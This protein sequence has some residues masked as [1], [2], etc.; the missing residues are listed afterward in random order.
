[1]K[2]SE[3]QAFLQ[4]WCSAKTAKNMKQ[5]LYNLDLYVETGSLDPKF[6]L[7]LA[8]SMKVSRS[9]AN[10][11]EMTR[12]FATVPDH[13]FDD[14][15]KKDPFGINTLKHFL[16]EIKPSQTEYA[17]IT[18]F[19]DSS[20]GSLGEIDA[21]TGHIFT[22]HNVPIAI[23]ILEKCLTLIPKEN[24]WSRPE[25]IPFKIGLEAKVLSNIVGAQ[26]NPYLW[27]CLITPIQAELNKENSPVWA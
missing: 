15:P 12:H 13:Y 2:K 1:M 21:Q 22:S 23:P 14:L 20:L 4:F 6:S 25:P 24:S 10:Q 8:Q 19:M 17:F 7:I 18:R 9:P 27:G 11:V 5:P 16:S 3:P 26:L